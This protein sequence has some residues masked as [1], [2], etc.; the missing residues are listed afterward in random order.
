MEYVKKE[1]ADKMRL[2]NF[3]KNRGK[4]GAVRAVRS[5]D[6]HTVVT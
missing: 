2:L 1:G 3:V 6:S 5:H 4:G